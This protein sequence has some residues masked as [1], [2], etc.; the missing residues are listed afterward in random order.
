MIRSLSLAALL[1]LSACAPSQLS[2]APLPGGSAETTVLIVRHAEKRTDQGDD[3]ELSAEGSARARALE[4]ALASAG[5]EAII[6]SQF[7]RTTDTVAPL[8]R[9]LGLTVITRPLD[10]RDSPKAAAELA[11]VLAREFAGKTI[12]VAG[13]SNTINRMVSALT[14]IEMAELEGTDYDNLFIVRIERSGRATLIRSQFGA[15]DPGS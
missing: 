7:R 4:V 1:L 5:V 3:P 15:P 14:G 13:H 8:A 9:R 2:T 11:P 6:G 10:T 12:L